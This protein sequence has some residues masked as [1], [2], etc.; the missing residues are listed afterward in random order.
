M[1][2]EIIDFSFQTGTGII[3]SIKGDRFLF[4]GSEWKG[5][6]FPERGLLIDFEPR[7]NYAYQIYPLKFTNKS[8]DKLVAG[9][10]AL[11]LGCF[12]IHKF[13]L[14]FPVP[15]LIFLLINTT[16]I[17]LNCVTFGM[18]IVTTAMISFIEGI[19]YLSKTDSDF[20]QSYV[21]DKKEW[22]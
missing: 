18:P 22:F 13:Y 8:K 10:L 3:S 4:I 7:G 6:G 11:F 15:G 21:I 9:L 1:R 20:Y 19:I 16:G 5:T 2:G 14:G 12:G 17:P